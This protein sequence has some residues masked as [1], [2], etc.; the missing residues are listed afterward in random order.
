MVWSL[1]GEAPL[2]GPVVFAGWAGHVAVLSRRLTQARRD[3]LTGA[4]TR[5]AFRARAGR[6]RGHR[7]VVV[8]VD[9]DGF[10]AVNDTFGHAAGDAV[11]VATV[12]RLGRV[13]PRG[14]VVGRL[15][16]DEF[17]AVGPLR[18]GRDE[19]DVLADVWTALTVPVPFGDR[20]LSVGA[21]C[22]GVPFPA[23]SDLS[24]ALGNADQAMYEAKASGG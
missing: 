10:K 1:V 16:G 5:A 6:G 8:L 4:W 17:A 24:T 21:S 20:V 7:R 12:E 11:L 3:P 22:G 19:G 23:G 13:L 9:L 18:A 14:S 15:G 2:A